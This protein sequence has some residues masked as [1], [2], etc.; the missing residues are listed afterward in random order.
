MVVEFACFAFGIGA[1][2]AIRRIRDKADRYEARSLCAYRN[3][4]DV[5]I[6]VRLTQDM[7]FGD[8]YAIVNAVIDSRDPDI[9]RLPFVVKSARLRFF[10]NSGDRINEANWKELDDK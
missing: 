5:L 3:D 7:A 10:T 6:L 8:D 2:M 9:H 4:K 1:G